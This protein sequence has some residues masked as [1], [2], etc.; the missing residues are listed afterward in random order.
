ME[1]I[2][3]VYVSKE[4]VFLLLPEWLDGM[5]GH[6]RVAPNITTNGQTNDSLIT[7]FKLLNTEEIKT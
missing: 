1:P 5:L 3:H 7:E 6:L 2:L 4:K